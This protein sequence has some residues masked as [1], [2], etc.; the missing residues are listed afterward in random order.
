MG[1]AHNSCYDTLQPV[2]SFLWSHITEQDAPRLGGCLLSGGRLQVKNQGR[3]LA[4]RL[5]LLGHLAALV[6]QLE[7]SSLVGGRLRALLLAGSMKAAAP[8]PW[9]GAEADLGLLLGVYRHGYSNYRAVKE[10]EHLARAFKVSWWDRLGVRVVMCRVWCVMGEGM[11]G[12]WGVGRG[13]GLMQVRYWSSPSTSM[14]PVDVD[15]C[16]TFCA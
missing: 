16:N 4:R 6:Q 3:A 2:R 15:V 10:D 11:G 5:Q 8:V 14:V 7:G 12:R 1:C 13:D 9:W